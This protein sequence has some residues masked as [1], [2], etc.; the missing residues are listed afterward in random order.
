MRALLHITESSCIFINGRFIGSLGNAGYAGFYFL[1]SLFSTALIAITVWKEKRGTWKKVLLGVAAAVFILFILL[2]KTR[3]AFLGLVGGSV[4]SALF[5]LWY[6]PPSIK[7][8]AKRAFICIFLVITA[9]VLAGFALPERYCPLCH[10]FTNISPKNA[11]NEPRILVW[12]TSLEGIRERPIFGWGPENFY[13]AFNKRFDTRHFNPQDPTGSEI[14]V[15]R[16]HNIYL[17]Y[18]I[19]AGVLGFGSFIA[20]FGVLYWRLFL[21]MKK[22]KDALSPQALFTTAAIAGFSIAYLING[23]FEVEAFATT[24]NLFIFLAFSSWFLAA[25]HENEKKIKR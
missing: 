4:G 21:F 13:A 9:L 25:D 24:F 19:D 17:Q 7:K 16:P 12:K 8:Y 2:S 22:R 23:F 3:A 14:R 10:R 11:A 5:L 18:F 6:G 15:D 1:F 20:I